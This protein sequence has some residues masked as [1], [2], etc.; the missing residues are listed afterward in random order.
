MSS[1]CESSDSA[2]RTGQL[3]VGLGLG[4]LYGL[5]LQ[6]SGV[7]NHD[8]VLGTLRLQQ[9]TLAKVMLAAVVV[10]SVGVYGLRQAGL[11][12][13]QIGSASIGGNVLGGLMFGAGLAMLG[14][15]PGTVVGAA[16]EARLDAL[17]AGVPGMMIGSALYALV[18]R[19]VVALKQMGCMGERTFW[20]LLGVNPWAVLV[21]LSVLAIGVLWMFELMGL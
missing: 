3:M 6:K 9:M 20:Q 1:D 5:A 10:G 12:E 17:I 8:V 7:T 19:D 15:C 21:P 13:L 18:H 4:L 11:L 16:G 14:Y 2:G